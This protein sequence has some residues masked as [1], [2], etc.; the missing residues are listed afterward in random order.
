[1]IS[2][3]SLRAA[4][5]EHVNVWHS[6]LAE[7]CSKAPEGR[8]LVTLVS[9]PRES[10]Y[11]G[12]PPYALVRAEGDATVRKYQVESPDIRALLESIAPD[13]QIWIQAA[14]GKDS[15]QSL[16]AWT[17]EGA[18]IPQPGAA[19]AAPSAPAAQPK[20][21]PPPPPRPAPVP[22]GGA[23]AEIPAE[24]PAAPPARREGRDTIAAD[25]WS[26]LLEARRLRQRYVKEFGE[27][28]S[29]EDLRLAN[30]LH[31]QL[32]IDGGW[33]ALSRR[34]PTAEDLRTATDT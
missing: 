2:A 14:G 23:P 6:S 7:A 16:A 32:N 9:P 10:R 30:A 26:C 4:M 22:N 33:R 21:A 31:I 3:M 11:A 5:F 29:D 20:S 13:T 15:G 1:M 18:R 19:P 34:P 27:P 24:T 28:P 17:A 12:R 25:L 8:L